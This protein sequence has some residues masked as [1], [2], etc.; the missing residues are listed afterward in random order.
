MDEYTLYLDESYTYKKN[1]KQPA[2]AIGGFITRN[3]NINT[4]F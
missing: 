4:W 1:G 2:F 3:S